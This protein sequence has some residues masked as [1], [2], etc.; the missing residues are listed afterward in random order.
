MNKSRRGAALAM[1]LVV[2]LVGGVM[3]ALIFNMV[4]RYAWF[5]PEERAGFV[6][7]TTVL[8]FIQREKARI[9]HENI[10]RAKD[11]EAVIHATALIERQKNLAFPH[12]ADLVLADLV[13]GREVI[14]VSNETGVGRDRVVVTVYDMFFDPSWLNFTALSPDDLRNLPPILNFL[15]TTES[16]GLTSDGGGGGGALTPGAGTSDGDDEQGP[17]PDTYGAYLIRAELFDRQNNIVRMAEEAF[18]QIVSRDA[19]P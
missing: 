1:A 12:P 8:H 18:V 6:D 5:T 15:G 4:F 19:E 9:L 10:E 13:I 14:D 7:H 2:V 17:D 11:G 3:I 16:G